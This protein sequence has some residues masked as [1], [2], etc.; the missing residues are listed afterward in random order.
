MREANNW[1]QQIIKEFREN[2]G[3]VGGPFAGGT[4]L[5]LHTIGAKTGEPRLNPLAYLDV[6]PN[7]YAIF[8]SKAGAPSNPDWYHNLLAHPDV[9]VEIGTETFPAR[10]RVAT[11]EERER[12]WTR[13]KQVMPGFAEYEKKTSRQIP[14][15]I[16]ERSA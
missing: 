1:N 7:Q 16:L 5:L 6:G 14:V 13:Q 9:T 12:I 8:A 3:K 2:G 10:A 15:I 4:L 11:G